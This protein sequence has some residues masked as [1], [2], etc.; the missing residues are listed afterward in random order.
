M[1]IAFRGVVDALSE[2]RLPRAISVLG[3]NHN[4]QSS[5]GV[6]AEVIRAIRDWIAHS[7]DEAMR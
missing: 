7:V 1:G 2:I 3:Y 6:S 5:F 4:L